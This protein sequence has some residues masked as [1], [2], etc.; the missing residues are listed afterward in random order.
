[1]SESENVRI[2]E[3]QKTSVSEN[4]WIFKNWNFHNLKMSES[5]KTGKCQNLKMSE[6][7]KTGKCQNLKMSEYFKTWKCVLHKMFT[8]KRTTRCHTLN[9]LDP[10]DFRNSSSRGLF[11]LPV[12]LF[13]YWR[14]KKKKKENKKMDAM[15]PSPHSCQDYEAN[16]LYL[17]L[18]RRGQTVIGT[19]CCSVQA[20]ID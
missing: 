12:T 1:M 5:L 20:C 17:A 15:P 4:I 8:I 19:D 13:L 9:S 10:R 14:E 7:L 11:L 3:N 2:F 6:F 16:W 18:F